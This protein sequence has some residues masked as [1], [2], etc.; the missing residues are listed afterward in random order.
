MREMRAEMLT[1]TSFRP[2][3]YS[4]RVGSRGSLKTPNL[5]LLSPNVVLRCKGKYTGRRAREKK[6]PY[7]GE[8]TTTR[9]N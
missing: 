3:Y 4:L 8:R 6:V 9:G 2:V 5:L 1:L 7:A